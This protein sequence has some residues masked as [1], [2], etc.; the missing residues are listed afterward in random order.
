MN[1]DEPKPIDGF[2][3]SINKDRFAALMADFINET[4]DEEAI[5]LWK[6]IT[7]KYPSLP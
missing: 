5:E 2:Q 3:D 4:T 6:M 1:K 7:S